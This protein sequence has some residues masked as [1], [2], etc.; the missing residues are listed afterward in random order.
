MFII[1][2]KDG[3]TP[4]HMAADNGVESIVSVL[5]VAGASINETNFVSYHNFNCVYI[6]FH[7]YLLYLIRVDGLLFI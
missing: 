7:L 6:Y 5:L 3:W 4:L 2:N 1:S